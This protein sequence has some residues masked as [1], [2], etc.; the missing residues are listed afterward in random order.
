MVVVV[1]IVVFVVV[2]SSSS[3]C[4]YAVHVWWPPRQDLSLV[5][6]RPLRSCF[7]IA[8][9]G[10]KNSTA[11]VRTQNILLQSPQIWPSNFN[12]FLLFYSSAALRSRDPKR[13]SYDYCSKRV[14]VS[15]PVTRATVLYPSTR[16]PLNTSL[17]F[18]KSWNQR[19][20]KFDIYVSCSLHL[21]KVPPVD[22]KTNPLMW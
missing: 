3:C 2:D 16:V 14:P 18:L 6:L 12:K 17:Y 11:Y 7:R 13:G 4:W 20:F 9:A 8:F 22:T 1:V 19:K 10:W 5:P 15:I 21:L